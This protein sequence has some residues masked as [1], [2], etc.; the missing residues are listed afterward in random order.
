MIKVSFKPLS[1]NDAWKGRRFKT[2]A[3]KAYEK[4]VLLILP[5]QIIPN[6]KLKLSIQANVSNTQSDIDNPVKPFMDILQKKYG[7][8]DCRVYELNVKKRIVK[9]G[10]ESIL[11]K[12]ES[13][14]DEF[15]VQNV[16]Q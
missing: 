9:K 3:Y 15:N 1:V 2:D 16:S 4:Y 14:D 13:I 5:K 7:F 6:G 11:F 8:N 10:S 12:I